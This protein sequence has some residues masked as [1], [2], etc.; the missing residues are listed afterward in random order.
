[1]QHTG[2]IF[3][4]RGGSGVQGYGQ[5]VPLN[6][7]APPDVTVASEMERLRGAVNRL[8]QIA[9]SS[10]A[11]AVMIQGHIP[12][13]DANPRAPAEA[14]NGHIEALNVLAHEIEVQVIRLEIANKRTL[15]ALG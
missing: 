8:G 7:A 2:S 3:T 1:M 4:A 6:N 15:Q 11:I 10:E 9:S 12:N 14:P 13:G 5:S